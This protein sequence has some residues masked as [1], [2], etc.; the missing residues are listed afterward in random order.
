MRRYI[1]KLTEAFRKADLILLL[2]CVVTTVFGLLIIASTTNASAQGP[3][4]YLGVQIGAAIAGVL[5]YLFFSSIDTEFF[6]ERRNV[7][8]A[9]NTVALLLLVPFGTDLG[10]GNKSW[11]NFPFLP[12]DIQP[13]EVCKISFVLVMA[14]VM[15]S[16][17]NNISSPLSIGY[18]IFNMILVVGLNLLV[19]RDMGVS[20]IFVFIT[21]G[22]VW[23]GGVSILWF[24]T[25]FAGLALMAPLAWEFFLNDNQRKRI[26]VLFNPSLD[27]QGTGALYHTNRALRS[28]TGGGL[29][30]QGLFQGNR[31]Q[32]RGALFAQHTDFIFA[33]IGEELGFLGCAVVLLLLALIVARC[34]WVGNRSTDYLRKL[35]CYGTAAALIFQIVI[36]IGMCI[37]VM[38]VIGLTLPFIS[39]GGSSLITLYAMLG[40]VSGVYAR[41]HPTSHERYIRAPIQH[42]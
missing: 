42:L 16:R 7:L 17:Q 8:I 35:V 3:L 34:I 22:M 1:N 10:T 29:T 41:P 31:T 38:P 6:S 39:Y 11:L 20:L 15:A 19:S 14:S 18:I 2:L 27:P 4:R 36:N 37:G 33:A 32:T 21:V 26:M 25:A 9:F 5:A 12:F 13:A 28:L 23:A 30:G 40:L 24:L